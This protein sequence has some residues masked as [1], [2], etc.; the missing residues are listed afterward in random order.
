MLCYC[1]KV[2]M[3]ILNVIILP[4]SSDGKLRYSEVKTF[5]Q[6]KESVTA[7]YML[8]KT[9]WNSS[10]SLSENHLIYT[11]KGFDNKFTPM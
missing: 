9:S 7:V 3:A 1:N 2:A 11:R 10:I 8:I 6:K 5:L 4:V